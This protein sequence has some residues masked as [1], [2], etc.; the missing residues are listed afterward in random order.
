VSANWDALVIGAGPNGLV[1]ATTLARQGW[2]VLVLEA[3]NRPGGA[4]YSQELT[5][6]GYTHDVGAAFFP[7][8]DDS[9]AFRYLDLTG[10]GL[11]WRNAR[12]ESCHPAPDGSC[13]S[14]SRDIDLSVKSFGADGSAWRRLAEWKRAMGGRLAS[15]L[16][17]PLPGLG[18][19]W[20]LGPRH[21]ARLGL[22]GLRTPAGW[23]QRYFQTE[24]ARRIVPSLA[25]HVDLG[26]NDFAGAGL[27]LVLALLAAESGFRV[28]VGGARSITQALL[29]R[30]EEAGG[31]LQLGSHVQR[32]LVRRNK[33]VAIRTDQGEEV[34]VQRAVLADVGAPAL[35]LKL[36]ETGSV[37]R[38]LLKSMRRFRYGWGTFKMDWA[39]AGPV[40]WLAEE[41]R[42]SAVV[43]AGDSLE[44]L[45]AFTQEVRA[46]QLPAHPYLVIGQQSLVDPS[47]APAGCHTLWAYSHAPSYI[48]GGW[49]KHREMFAD[50]IEERIEE[51]APGFRALIRGRAIHSPAD[52]EAMDENLVGG[53]LGGG[54]ACFGQ[55]LF[56][57]PVF[58]YFRYRTPVRGLYLASA[59]THPGAGVHGACGFNAAR[60][61]LWDCCGIRV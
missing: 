19:A 39:L 53:D 36:L 8:A 61:A 10:A 3:K 59:S 22:Y 24:A 12:W 37:G 23:A 45:T 17:A 34:P 40:P 1:A 48:E 57:R 41:A 46:G 51:L 33:A 55:Q 31:H 25:L 58:P 56:F 6:P 52:L 44:D 28:P 26:P 2:R 18:P 38:W 20:R 13:A 54:S 15:A 43:H 47:R 42:D 9:P 5:L 32:I 11:E 14:I 29:R 16:L 50:R 4:V 60:M 7:F 30:L 35:Y 49:H 21:V 27:G